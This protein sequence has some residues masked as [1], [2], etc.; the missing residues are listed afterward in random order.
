MKVLERQ[1][2]G[3]SEPPVPEPGP[4]R[5]THE[6]HAP[7]RARQAG[8]TG[9]GLA[10]LLAAVH[11]V[12]DALVTIP[13]VLL[14]S[15][16]GRFGLSELALSAIV[17]LL[18]FSSSVTQ[19]LFGALADR[20]GPRA[21]AVGGV[22][23]SS[24]VFS[25]IGVVPV[26]WMVFAVVLVA[27][28]GSAAL[29]PVGSSLARGQGGQRGDMAVSLFSAGGMLGFA[30]GPIGI[31]ALVGALGLGGT[32]WLMVPGLLLAASLFVA[33]PAKRAVGSARGSRAR[34]I[35]LNLL[36][37]PIGL[38]VVGGVLADMAFVTFSSAMPLWLVREQGAAVDAPLIAATLAAFSLAAAGGSVAAGYLSRHVPRRALVVGTLLGALVPL[39]M[40][41]HLPAGSVAFFVA[42]TLAGAL[43][44]ANFPLLILTAQDLAPGAVATA[45]GMLMGL[46]TGVAGM[47]Y[48]AV[49]ALQELVG[50]TTA[51]TIAYLGLL[52]AALV[53]H[54]V[55]GGRRPSMARGRGATR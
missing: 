40:A 45:S 23:I 1:R 39:V 10:V 25:L 35:D 16:Q 27:G 48:I 44:Y 17:A 11:A 51:I 6:A 49:G 55:L 50:L 31:I 43:T 19:P 9:A 12:N 34:Y 29:H 38:L 37:G 22:V 18:W 42:V 5:T 20:F 13:S 15:L 36:R 53:A 28:L 21:L 14:P 26:A 47:L 33:I 24:A 3:P 54:V 30:I 8:L 2:P 41:L 7:R 46:A 52:P 32:P 4:A